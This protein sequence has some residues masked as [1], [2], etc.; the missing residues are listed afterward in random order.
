MTEYC[1]SLTLNNNNNINRWGTFKD[2]T[3]GQANKTTVNHETM[4]RES[5]LAMYKET[6]EEDYFYSAIDNSSMVLEFKGG[7]TFRKN[8]YNPFKL[9]YAV[10]DYSNLNLSLND[11]TFYIKTYRPIIRG[12]LHTIS[13]LLLINCKTSEESVDGII[14]QLLNC[15]NVLFSRD[16]IKQRYA[17]AVFSAFTVYYP[18][19]ISWYSNYTG[20][21][22]SAQE[23]LFSN[24]GAVYNFTCFVKKYNINT[25]AINWSSE[26]YHTYKFSDIY[27]MAV[28]TTEE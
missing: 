4:C 16:G 21:A 20:I 14:D 3:L 22:S 10:H 17:H 8:V 7:P 12:Y 25:D 26:V 5:L 23:L 2:L 18:R 27:K 24:K 15:Y 9:D 19:I 6:S 11:N 28:E 1:F 13:F